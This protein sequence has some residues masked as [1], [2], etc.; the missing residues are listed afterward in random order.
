M[1]YAYE[2]MRHK[3]NKNSTLLAIKASK[4]NYN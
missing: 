3:F 1:R 4:S 2:D